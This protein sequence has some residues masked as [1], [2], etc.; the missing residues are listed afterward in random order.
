MLSA[1]DLRWVRVKIGSATPPSDEDLSAAYTRLGDD[2]VAVVREVLNERLGNLLT[3]PTQVTVS[4]EYSRDTRGL[5]EALRHA[6]ERD[7]DL[8]TDADPVG[9][10]VTIKAPAPPC[11][12]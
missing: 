3:A 7:P 12:R 5:I 1:D 9:Y 2:R 6:L 11:Y 8:S 4:G 10:N